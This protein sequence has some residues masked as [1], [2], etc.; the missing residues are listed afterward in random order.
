M[1]WTDESFS[2]G[3]IL[4]SDE[5][6]EM[7]ANFEAMANGDSGA[8]RLDW[9]AFTRDITYTEQYV[10]LPPVSSAP[11][12][13]YSFNKGLYMVHV[14]GLS[15]NL[16]FIEHLYK[17]PKHYTVSYAV[18]GAHGVPFLYVHEDFQYRIRNNSSSNTVEIKILRFD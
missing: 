16:V 2:F 10:N 18:N 15:G 6:T 14:P 13:I 4:A 1:T 5:M 7:Q 3:A 9:E 17:W 12:N 8:P 11:D